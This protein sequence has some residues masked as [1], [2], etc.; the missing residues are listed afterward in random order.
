MFC[1]LFFTSSK[2]W[3]QERILHPFVVYSYPCKVAILV[4]Y[5][6]PTIL[7]NHLRNIY[8]KGYLVMYV[9]LSYSN[10]FHLNLDIK[11]FYHISLGSE[12][13]KGQTI[14]YFFVWFML[15]SAPGKVLMRL[16]FN[17]QAT[18]RKRYIHCLQLY[19]IIMLTKPCAR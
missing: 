18:K 15:L 2:S 9:Y 1:Q 8:A 16:I 3:L 12:M 11:T 4:T 6:Y 19:G 10:F 17:S 5:H 13:A 7:L 14:L